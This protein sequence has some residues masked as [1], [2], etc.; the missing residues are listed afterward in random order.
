MTDR[1]TRKQYADLDF[2]Q[3]TREPARIV[4]LPLPEDRDEAATK[5]YVDGTAGED[6]MFEMAR[7]KTALFLFFDINVDE[8]EPLPEF[9]T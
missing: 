6:L 2:G 1:P 4:H 7:I 8:L 9:L 3:D 5:R